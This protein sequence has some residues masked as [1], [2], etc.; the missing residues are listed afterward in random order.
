MHRI[1]LYSRVP[2]AVPPIHM[3]IAPPPWSPG[4]AD[5]VSHLAP[6]TS[7]VLDISKSQSVPPPNTWLAISNVSPPR[8]VGHFVV[9]YRYRMFG[10]DASVFFC[11]A[12]KI[13]QHIYKW[14]A[15]MK[16]II[17]FSDAQY[18]PCKSLVLW[19]VIE[20]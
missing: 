13:C 17:L 11:T 2:T 4:L 5:K 8:G 3:C 10:M 7:S 1:L 18:G 16:M 12:S 15:M 6:S 9:L 14:I 20:G 19:Y